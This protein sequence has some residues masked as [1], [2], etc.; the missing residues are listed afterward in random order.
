M[1]LIEKTLSDNTTVEVALPSLITTAGFENNISAGDSNLYLRQFFATGQAANYLAAIP[2]IRQE[3]VPKMIPDAK[4][5][6]EYVR[7]MDFTAP[8]K[9]ARI[10]KILL[11]VDS[12]SDNLVYQLNSSPPFADIAADNVITQM[13]PACQRLATRDC[14]KDGNPDTG[15]TNATGNPDIAKRMVKYRVVMSGNRSEEELKA[16]EAALKTD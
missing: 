2:G 13:D 12:A 9:Q 6:V 7:S 3:V 10:E 5:L 14:N 15:G 1:P 11:L 16:W 8:Q 4:V